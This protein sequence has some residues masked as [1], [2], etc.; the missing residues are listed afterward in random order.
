M[1]FEEG[2][3]IF[4]E[5]VNEGAFAG[6]DGVSAGDEELV[7]VSGNGRFPLYP[8]IYIRKTDNPIKLTG[9]RLE[10]R[11]VRVNRVQPV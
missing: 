5:A 8:C 7:D 9:N 11:Q 3:T 6:D 1:F 2:A 4:E 10:I